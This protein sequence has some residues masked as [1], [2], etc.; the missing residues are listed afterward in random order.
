M[1]CLGRRNRACHLGRDA[2][3]LQDKE[4]GR[5]LPNVHN[6]SLIDLATPPWSPP[7][8]GERG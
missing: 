5:N 3:A 2:I 7:K 8:P 6:Q 4:M 1:P